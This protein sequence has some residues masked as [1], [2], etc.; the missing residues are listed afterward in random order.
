MKRFCIFLIA[1]L[2]VGICSVSAQDTINT[3]IGNIIRGKILKV[4]PTSIIYQRPDNSEVP[5]IISRTNVHSIEFSDGRSEI[6]NSAP[7]KIANIRK[8]PASTAGDNKQAPRTTTVIPA[9]PR[10]ATTA[11]QSQESGQSTAPASASQSGDLN[12]LKQALNL[13][14]AVPIAGKNIKFEF[15]VN[16]WTAK[17]NGQNFLSGDCT[18]QKSGNGYAITLKPTNVWSGAVDEVIDLMQNVGV[19]LGP[20]ASPLKMAAKLASKLAKWLPLKG[21]AIVLDYNE[22]SPVPLKLKGK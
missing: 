15:G 16:D 21:S 18:F 5:V 19:P 2:W 17:V 8:P 9:Q 22:E 20:A 13:V 7:L 10:P 12:L 1:F 14:P 3:R 4:T 11:Q 6:I